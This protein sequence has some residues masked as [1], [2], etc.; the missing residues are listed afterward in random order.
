MTG[1]QAKPANPEF[2][3]PEDFD[4]CVWRYM[5]MRKFHSMLTTSAIYLCRADR[6]ERFEGTYSREQLRDAA[7]YLTRIGHPELI[8]TEREQRLRDKRRTYI[9]CWCVASWDLDLMWKAYVGNKT[10][11][12]AVRSSPGRLH[13]LCQHHDLQP[14][15]ISV[16]KY[17]DHAGGQPIN[18]FGT[19]SAFVHK[20]H[21]FSLDNELRI[22]HWPNMQEPTPDHQLLKCDLRDVIDLVVLS[23]GTTE[24]ES[25]CVLQSLRAH[26]L[27]NIPVEVSRD[28]REAEE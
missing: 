25:R 18:Y 20:D 21:H 2:K 14:I 3:L 26:G 1:T 9:S 6:L 7:E 19:P 28:D 15:G 27:A 11:G 22:L 16:V 5:S 4:C 13:D 24:P 17:F 8:E 10:P 12:V 23:P